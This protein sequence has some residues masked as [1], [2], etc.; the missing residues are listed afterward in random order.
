MGQ[1]TQNSVHTPELDSVL[2]LV[3]QPCHT[4]SGHLECDAFDASDHL[5][6]GEGSSDD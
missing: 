6:V 3:F 4:Q 5:S 2:M 1:E